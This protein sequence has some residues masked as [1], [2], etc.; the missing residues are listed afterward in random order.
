LAEFVWDVSPR[1][2]AGTQDG[3]LIR[4][5]LMSY[6]KLRRTAALLQAVIIV[7]LPFVYVG[8][9]S[10]LRFDIPTMRLLF[11]GAEVWLGEFHFLLFSVLLFVMLIIASTLVFGRVWCGWACPQTVVGEIIVML[12]RG[13]GRVLPKKG[14]S[15][16]VSGQ[17]VRALIAAVM[18]A[19]VIWYFIPP[20]EMIPELAAWSMGAFTA[21][22]F[23]VMW[24]I[25][26]LNFSLLGHKFC[27]TVCPYSK[28]QSV[29]LD[30][31]SLV[32]AFDNSRAD[33]CR[34]CEQCV[35][36][37]PVGID[38][39][40][41]L[42]VECINC[43]QC[44]DACTRMMAKKGRPPL[45]DYIFGDR[46]AGL[47]DALTY[48]AVFFTAVVAGLVAALI[49]SGI[50]REPYTLR[51]LK[52][53]KTLYRQLPDGTVINTY[54]II[55]FNRTVKTAV[56]AAEVSGIEGAVLS[57]SGTEITVRPGAKSEYRAI[58]KA[59]PGVLSGP[60]SRPIAITLTETGGDTLSFE[61]AFITP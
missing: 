30:K 35:R 13:I 39:K 37:C 48:K 24:I 21:G 2:A 8:G 45:V 4:K 17:L 33:A 19:N 54:S 46:K 12:E 25:F 6:L 51:V 16:K 42:Q 50:S 49:Y 58:V 43:A 55:V 26:Y 41:G 14:P 47:R 53:G 61:A 29:L 31:N 40:D 27:G 5:P 38:I 7:G 59:G 52:E 18:S 9:E 3:I 22:A 57:V 23:V 36:D 11:F 28:M 32:I 10:A 56:F 15:R 60:K 1:L 44:V 34:G 20:Y